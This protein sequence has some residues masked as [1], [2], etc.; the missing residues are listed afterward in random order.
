M[1]IDLS[2]VIVENALWTCGEVHTTGVHHCEFPEIRAECGSVAEGVVHPIGLLKRA[3]ETTQSHWRHGLIDRA[4]AD[5]TES[6]GAPAE[7]G[8]YNESSCRCA[9]HIP[10]EIA[11]TPPGRLSSL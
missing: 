6:L 11:S 1:S 4:I 9:A 7:A 2:R 5:A 10:G 3:R 8:Q